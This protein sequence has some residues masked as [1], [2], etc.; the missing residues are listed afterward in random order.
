MRTLFISLAVGS[1]A[2][3]CVAKDGS[4]GRGDS[5]SAGDALGNGIEDSAGSYGPVNAGAMADAACVV[6]SGNTAD[7]DQDSIPADAKLTFNC[8][9]MALGYTGTLTGME[10]V[11]DNMP[12]AIAWAFTASADLHATLTGPFGGTIVRDWAGQIRATQAS[13][14]GPFALARTLDVTT[15]FTPPGAHPRVTTVTENNDWTI[16]FTP[17]VTWTPGGVAVVG[18][19][20]AT[21]TWNAAV[22]SH[23]VLATLSTPT[24]LT[25]T[26]SCA[27]RVTAGQVRG[28][29]EDD[30][31]MRSITVTWTACGQR[32][33]VLD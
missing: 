20:S 26:P 13:A 16:T 5:Q 4:L 21:G 6:L 2:V 28:T 18:S 15:V 24:A 11:V 9:A 23:D 10:G 22:D 17:M 31:V 8:T 27:T 29:F 12:A 32:T 3:G 1:L 7:T 19:L 14:A 33:V 30:A 25:L